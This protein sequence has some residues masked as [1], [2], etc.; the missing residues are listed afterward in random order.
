MD[1][2]YEPVVC[3]FCGNALDIKS[4]VVLLMHEN[5]EEEEAQQLY[6]HKKCINERLHESIPRY[7]DLNED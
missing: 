1:G 6:C 3:C 2:T 4:A 7:V 5:I